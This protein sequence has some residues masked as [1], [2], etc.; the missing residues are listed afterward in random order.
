MGDQ[1]DKVKEATSKPKSHQITEK[2]NDTSAT[3]KT[4][5]NGT[6]TKAAV[7]GSPSKTS[8]EKVET[9]K[10][11]LSMEERSGKFAAMAKKRG[12]SGDE[13]SES[14][15]KQEK[16]KSKKEI[17]AEAAPV[18]YVL[19][20]K[21]RRVKVIDD[22]AEEMDCEF[23]NNRQAFLNLCQGNHYQYDHLRRG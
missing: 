9:P 7:N 13:K 5:Q 21:G 1:S 20:S 16:E 8:P 15:G 2:K 23:L 11:T 18:I 6:G 12:F 14:D 19:D 3:P 10:S 22:D 4:S 17:A